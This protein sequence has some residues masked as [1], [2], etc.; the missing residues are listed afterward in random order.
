MGRGTGVGRVGPAWAVA[1]LAGLAAGAAGPA[2]E[3]EAGNSSG[4]GA[5]A[6]RGGP[7]GS[8]GAKASAAARQ[9][10]GIAIRAYRS[11]KSAVIT[12]TTSSVTDA[13]Q[14]NKPGPPQSSSRRNPPP[15]QLRT[16]PPRPT[17]SRT[18]S[19]APGR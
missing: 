9:I 11:E 6:R 1:E 13:A 10:T 19:S 12:G 7:P 14:G 17:S 2:G 3:R 16:I 4:A 15:R 8:R 18:P 5:A